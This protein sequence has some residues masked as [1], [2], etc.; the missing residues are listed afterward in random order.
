[1]TMIGR[2]GAPEAR[3]ETSSMS[4]VT[5]RDFLKVGAA[6]A[7]AAVGVTTLGFDTAAAVEVKQAFRMAGTKVAHSL[8]PYC[9][10]GCSMI[11]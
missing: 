6:S 7:G 2:S 10:V 4:Q 1:M 9:A 5:R 11:S 8:C 3:K